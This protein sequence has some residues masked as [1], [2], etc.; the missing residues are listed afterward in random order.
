MIRFRIAAL[1]SLLSGLTIVLLMLLI[2]Y[3][4][5]QNLQEYFR[6][7]LRAKARLEGQ[8][9]LEKD[10]M[11]IEI[12]QKIIDEHWVKLPKEEEYVIAVK[13]TSWAIRKGLLTHASV[14]ATIKEEN[15]YFA[16]K[17]RQ[18]ATLHYPD[19]Q[20]DFII[21]VSAV[22]EK[23]QQELSALRRSMFSS[24]IIIMIV[25]F[26]AGWG[27]AHT[28][29]N[30]LLQIA[31]QLK[32]INASE[33]SSRISI[34]NKKDELAQMVATLN[35][36]LNRLQNGIEIQKKF[37]SHASHE[38]K[39]PLTVILGESDVILRKE[40]EKDE[41]IKSI[42][43]I[44]KQGEK[45]T[46]VLTDLIQLMEVSSGGSQ[47]F[48]KT[49]FRIEDVVLDALTRMYEYSGKNLIE[50]DYNHYKEIDYEIE[51]NA[52]WLG[53]VF[54]NL[55]KNALKFSSFQKVKI[56]T[57]VITYKNAPAL[58]IDVID[59]GVGI[60][61]EDLSSLRNPFFRASNVTHIM[62][63]G[64]GLTIVDQIILLHKGEMHIQSKVNEGTTVSIILPLVI[65]DF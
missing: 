25:Q 40:R 22:D 30:P 10:E 35:E 16:S 1:F 14:L 62:G 41:Y 8:F 20:G 37:I 56:I 60:P 57:E 34:R 42:E 29:T 50:V 15:Y 54:S 48:E 3:N 39:T 46:E 53:I 33:L 4:T 58:K 45:L 49:R 26:A 59:T 38:L 24:L 17:G 13:D 55:L 61:A 65:S 18:W 43:T 51:G 64:I 9:V 23:G 6:E 27:F 2:Y 19:N 12:Y 7:D 5:E 28:V 11:D 63:H 31:H 21:L 32:R 52:R 44:R 36:M 47:Y